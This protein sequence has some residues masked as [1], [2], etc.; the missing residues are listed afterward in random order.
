MDM[1]LRNSVDGTLP[2]TRGGMTLLS[3]VTWF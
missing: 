3:G 2:L 1:K